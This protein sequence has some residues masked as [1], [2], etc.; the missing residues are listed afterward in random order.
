MP[1][2][3]TL[4]LPALTSG[5]L[6]LFRNRSFAV[7]LAIY[8]L[9]AFAAFGSFLTIAQYLQ[10]VLALGPFEAGLWTA[11]SGASF[12]AGS[13]VAPA[14]ARRFA[15]VTIGVTTTICALALVAAAVTAGLLLRTS[16]RREP[17]TET[18]TCL[19]PDAQALQPD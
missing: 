5:D 1:G 13:M 4:R 7:C 18:E 10:T 6:S 3:R 2:D 12:I 8:V 14:L 9:G 16:P 19:S 15:T 11:T 17:E